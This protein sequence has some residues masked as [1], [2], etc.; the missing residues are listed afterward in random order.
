MLRQWPH[1]NKPKQLNSTFVF[2]KV[3]MKWSSALSKLSGGAQEA[4][5][6][7]IPPYAEHTVKP[8]NSVSNPF[9]FHAIFTI[10]RGAQEASGCAGAL[11]HAVI[12]CTCQYRMLLSC[13]VAT[14]SYGI[15][16]SSELHSL[17]RVWSWRS[18]SWWP[19]A[20]CVCVSALTELWSQ[21]RTRVIEIMRVEAICG[22]WAENKKSICAEKWHWMF[23]ITVLCL[24]SRGHKNNVNGNKTYLST[25]II[26]FS[27]LC[28][29][30]CGSTYVL[31]KGR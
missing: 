24:Q 2:E 23:Y 4:G 30:F 3:R 18:C 1:Q 7:V 27:L 14:S 21:F 29:D 22:L 5:A 10:V 26:P 28:K 11:A 8:V 15:L 20:A 25:L 31:K 13:S 6:A 17:Q 12:Q 9:A 16:S 19:P